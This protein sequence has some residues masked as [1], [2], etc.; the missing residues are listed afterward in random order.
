MQRLIIFSTL[1][2]F[3]LL[4][5]SCSERIIEPLQVIVPKINAPDF[6]RPGE[7]IT[8]VC[9]TENAV[10][11]YTVDGSIPTENSPRYGGMLTIGEAPLTAEHVTL[12]AKAFKQ[13][14]TPSEVATLEYDI[15]Y[16][17][18][19][20]TPN[21]YTP[22]MS[23]TISTL[24]NISITCGTLGATIRYT[25]DGSDPDSESTQYTGIFNIPTPGVY[26]IKA[27]AFKTSFNPSEIAAREIT[28][29][30][31]LIVETPS[32]SLPD[33]SYNG[34]VQIVISC[35]T[36]GALVRYTTDG[37]EPDATSTPYT[38]ALILGD[39]TTDS[40][41]IKAKGFR[42][43]MTPSATATANYSLE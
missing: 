15:E 34:N 36:T 1:L 11:R 31:P 18:T 37:S 26:T 8:I 21:I 28:V 2:L 35:A 23:A 17:V 41:T 39:I 29:T 19:V 20:A 16:F 9:E 40:V 38:Q 10:I 32:F 22:G 13:G 6:F 30:E 7:H 27:R 3:A 4:A 5:A 25:L 14:M 12:K 43:G 33:G 42:E 24:D